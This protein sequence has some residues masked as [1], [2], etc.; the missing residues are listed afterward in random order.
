MQRNINQMLLKYD[1][2]VR[3][4]TEENAL[5]F[6]EKTRGVHRWVFLATFL[7]FLILVY[8]PLHY[9]VTFT[10]KS[11]EAAVRGWGLNTSRSTSLYVAPNNDTT[12]ISDSQLCSEPLLLL[13]I[14]CS[15]PNNTLERT[16]IR[17]TWGNFSSPS[18]K[19]AFLLG[20]T[21]NSTLQE[22]IEEEATIH[23]DI[24]QENFVDSYNNLT[25][26]TVM[27]LKYVYAHCDKVD[28]ILKSDDDMFVH[29][30]NLVTFLKKFSDKSVKHFLMGQLICYSK[31]IL[32]SNNKWYTPKY[33]YQGKVYPNYLSGTG[34][35]M[36]RK[37]AIL[38]YQTALTTPL[39]HLEDVYIT[40][41]CAKRANIKPLHHYGFTLSTRP[42]DPCLYKKNTNIFT[43]HR[44]TL[45]NMKQLWSGLNNETLCTGT[46]NSR[47]MDLRK[48]STSKQKRC[49]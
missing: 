48:L 19:V 12:L 35:L 30:Q 47:M 42:L 23:N 32:D 46:R 28:Y 18:Y 10:R 20:V 24:I 15:A 49:S 27:L 3:K 13:I 9:Q 44:V 26:K 33:M 17:E 16:V 34:Y 22:N 31:P 45:E 14:V 29:V 25:L 6:R 11:V 4:T 2:V 36:D 21:E 40:G 41:I 8:V 37:T 38:L 39:L 5:M 1:L 7:F 43:S